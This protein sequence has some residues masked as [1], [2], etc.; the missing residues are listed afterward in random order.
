MVCT[1]R[2]VPQDRLLRK[3]D[4]AVEAVEIERIYK[5]VGD[6]HS[7]DNGRPS[8]DPVALFNLVLIQ[9]LYGIRSLRQTVKDAEVNIT[10]RWF[11]DH[12][13]A[14]PIPHFATI[15]YAFAQRFTGEI[16]ERIFEWI[17]DEVNEAG[18]LAWYL[19]MEPTSKPTQTSRS[20]SRRSLRKRRNDTKSSQ[21]R[22]STRS[23]K[24][25]GRNLL[26][27]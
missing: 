17:L 20:I 19:W 8:V 5:I 18:Y 22:K 2:L 7:I 10:Y 21:W 11:I 23:G 15:R 14:Q 1:D 3:L 4:A 16:V 24:P 25:T 6:L 12:T 27:T 9:R 13:A 26:T